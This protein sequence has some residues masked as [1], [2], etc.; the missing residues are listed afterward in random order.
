[1]TSDGGLRVKGVCGFVASGLQGWTGLDWRFA[2][3]DIYTGKEV[4]LT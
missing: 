1:M 4:L 3:V 2:I